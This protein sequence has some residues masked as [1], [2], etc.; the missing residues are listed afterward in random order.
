L[1]GLYAL[2]YR[3]F[4]TLRIIGASICLLI[5]CF[6]LDFALPDLGWVEK[7]GG[8]NQVFE[9]VVEQVVV[10]SGLLFRIGRRLIR[11]HV[12]P[13]LTGDL[14][15]IILGNRQQYSGEMHY[16]ARPR[17]SVW[18]YRPYF[19]SMILEFQTDFIPLITTGVKVHTIR[20][21]NRWSAGQSIKF[22]VNVGQDG[23]RKFWPD[24]VAQNVQNIR[25]EVSHGTPVIEINGRQLSAP[26]LTEFTHRDGFESPGLLLQFLDGYHGLPFVGQLIHWSSLRY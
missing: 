21:G 9:Q 3:K 7:T 13:T 10:G 26:E 23:M 14:T 5:Q 11:V 17:W 22:Y 4:G 19:N 1:S 6:Q 25:V 15:A 8:G 16:T 24:G 18:R 12:S 20:F 2:D